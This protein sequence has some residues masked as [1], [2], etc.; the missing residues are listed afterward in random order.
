MFKLSRSRGQDGYSRIIVRQCSVRHTARRLQKLPDVFDSWSR[1][2]D[3]GKKYRDMV[4][5]L[6]RGAAKKGDQVE[7]F[8]GE[9]GEKKKK[10]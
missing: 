6:L 4:A 8:L 1:A 10:T 2:R 5:Q 3:R 7:L 9:L